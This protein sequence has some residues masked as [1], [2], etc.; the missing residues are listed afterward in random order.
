MFY[1]LSAPEVI[2][3]LRAE[4]ETVILATD[5]TTTPPLSTLEQLPYLS[6][7]VNEAL[8]LSY[9]V[10]SRLP[11]SSPDEPIIYKNADETWMIPLGYAVGMSSYQIHHD[12]TLFPDSRTFKPERWLDE[13]GKRHKHLDQYL[14]SFS[15]GSRQCLGM[16]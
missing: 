4:L 3:K 16:K 6:A 11:R 14:L 2:E 5:P 13:R 1:L 7:C 12:E 8:R 10:G 15:K 9:G